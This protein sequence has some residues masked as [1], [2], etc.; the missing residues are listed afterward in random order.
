[1]SVAGLLR[2]GNYLWCLCCRYSTQAV[3]SVAVNPGDAEVQSLLVNLAGLDLHKVMA[4][5]KEPLLVP[6]YQLMTL[7]QL[8][9]V[10]S[11]SCYRV[12]CGRNPI[13]CFQCLT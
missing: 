3:Q 9:E 1:M 7:E 8:Q 11:F 2:R 6:H 12:L 4:R 10:D 5:R 13:P